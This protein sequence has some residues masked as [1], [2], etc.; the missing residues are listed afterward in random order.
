[1]NLAR[2]VYAVYLHENDRYYAYA[3]GNGGYFYRD[4]RGRTIGSLQ[5]FFIGLPSVWHHSD[6]SGNLVAYSGGCDT[7]AYDAYGQRVDPLKD[8]INE[9]LFYTGEQ[10]DNSAKQ[11]Y[12][13][14][15]YYNPLNGRF[16]RMDPFAGNNRDPQSLH[17]YLYA[18][19]NPVNGIDPSGNFFLTTMISFLWVQTKTLY[20]RT[21]KAV[22]TWRYYNRAR[23]ILIAI[24]VAAVVTS[25]FV[26][27]YV[28]GTAEFDL[29][30]SKQP[31]LKK[32]P[33]VKFA[34]SRNDMG[35]GILSFDVKKTSY[36]PAG[37]PMP[38]DPTDVAILAGF[39][40]NLDTGEFKNQT[41]A[42][43]IGV[44]ESFYK[45]WPVTASVAGNI[46]FP[47]P[48]EFNTKISLDFGLSSKRRSF[49]VDINLFKVSPNG[50]EFVYGIDWTGGF[51]A[52]KDND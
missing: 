32:W 27:N 48:L 21:H 18:H 12:L 28:K 43:D 25:S 38:G 31:M 45:Q 17:K 4:T 22:T 30:F 3:T 52:F 44:K 35:Q 16:N 23:S 39:D 24:S 6:A 46:K 29:N 2:P 10:W 13:R 40:L 47:L 36:G 26:T 5:A 34:L 8:S 42:A 7:F 9:G 37:E 15:R 1:M 19:N 51:S 49:G 20:M 50:F 41:L 11:Y 33:D 14:A